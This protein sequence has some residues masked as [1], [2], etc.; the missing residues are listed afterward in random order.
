ML[1]TTTVSILGYLAILGHGVA[2]PDGH[3]PGIY[4]GN[5][6]DPVDKHTRI[7]GDPAARDVYADP[8]ERR[9]EKPDVGDHTFCWRGGAIDGTKTF[10]AW[11]QLANM[12]E[13]YK[14]DEGVY[15]DWVDR[16]SVV[17]AIS[18]DVVAFFCNYGDKE[19][20]ES[21]CTDGGTRV[22]SENLAYKCDN[23]PGKFAILFNER[24]WLTTGRAGTD[25]HRL[26]KGSNWA[27]GQTYKERNFCSTEGGS[28]KQQQ[29]AGE[30][31]WG[32]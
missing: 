13:G 28:L 27:Y 3:P 2:I 26:E 19:G 24:G 1:A 17:Y 8:L 12:C 5:I 25:Y 16:A 15:E 30:T 4:A 20:Q 23:S 7:G 14:N 6:G 18:G 32:V 11:N 29:D 22:A 10:N 21:Y 31:E 9:G